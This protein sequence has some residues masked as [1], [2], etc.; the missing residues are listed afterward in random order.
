M[1]RVKFELGEITS[2]IKVA[3]V[4]NQLSF[5]AAGELPG[6]GVAS[7]GGHGAGNNRVRRISGSPLR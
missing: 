6:E 4:E 3:L 7:C 1:L 2:E 5:G